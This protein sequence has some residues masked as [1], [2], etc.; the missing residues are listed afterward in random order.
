MHRL[1]LLLLTALVPATIAAQPAALS[2]DW[3]VTM[4]FFGAT[5]YATLHVD[6]TG[7]NLKG[8]VAGTTFECQLR[9]GALRGEPPQRYESAEWHDQIDRPRQ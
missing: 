5:R 2:G 4:H 6:Q 3:Q 1:M 9:S 8:T 7:D